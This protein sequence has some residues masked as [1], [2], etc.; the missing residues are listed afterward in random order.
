MRLGGGGNV[1]VL[2]KDESKI[3]SMKFLIKLVFFTSLAF[4]DPKADTILSFR[5]LD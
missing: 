1:K 2:K 4:S 5:S 3:L